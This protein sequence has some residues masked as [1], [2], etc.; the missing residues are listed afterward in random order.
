MDNRGQAGFSLLEMM[1]SM[2]I[3]LVLMGIVST[4]LSGSLGIRSRE[5]Q[6]TDALTSAQAALNVMSR[7][8]ANSGFGISTGTSPRLPNNGIITADSGATQIHFRANVNNVGPINTTA[9][10]LT[11]DDVGEDLTYF[12][13]AS[14]KSIVRFDPNDAPQTSVVVNRISAVT[15]SYFDYVGPNSSGVQTST[16]TANTGRI[17]ITVQ[18]QLDPIQGQPN[19]SDVQFTSEVTLRNSPFM[20]NQY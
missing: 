15:F 3:M 14:S 18:V 12:F 4:L 6:H 9:G 10:V 17:R 13:D 11:T 7:E 19:P 8:I 5:S 2:T 20:L 16:P 1:V